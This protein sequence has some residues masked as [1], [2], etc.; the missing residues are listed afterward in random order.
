MPSNNNNTNW[1]KKSGSD[2]IYETTLSLNKYDD[3]NNPIDKTKGIVISRFNVSDGQIQFFEKVGSTE[4]LMTT[5]DAD[6]SQRFDSGNLYSTYFDADDSNNRGQQL[7]QVLDLTKNQAVTTAKEELSPEDFSDIFENSERYKSVSNDSQTDPDTADVSPESNPF[8][9]GSN[10]YNREPIPEGRALLRYPLT[11][12]DLGYD[13]I[14]I[15]AYEYTAGGR[16]SLTLGQ[17]LSAKKR[18]IR[19]ATKKETVILPMQPNFSESNAVSWGGDNLNPIQM[20][21]AGFAEGAIKAIGNLGAPDEAKKIIGETFKQLD[22]DVD[23]ILNDRISGPALIAYFAGQ[24]VGANILGRSAG[25]TLN[26]NLELLFKG[27]NLRTFNFNF[28]FTP[29]SPKEA[30]EVKEIIRVFKKNMAVQ[31]STSNLFL[32]TPRVFTVEYIYNAQGSSAGEI[33]P[34]L[35]IFKPMAM[36]NLNVNYTPDGT[37]MT[38]NQDGSLTSYDLQMSF[39]ELEPIY[40]DEFDDPDDDAV[41][42]FSQHKNMGY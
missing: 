18:I 31:R 12:P 13:F 42:S 3:P 11:V 37:Y 4:T 25:V 39:G 30:R 36:T 22:K 24:A 38:Y 19:D 26:P 34:Y 27:P 14:R 15:T 28:R 20:M 23:E 33:H 32:L 40:A 10:A 1:E 8:D 17:K 6:G 7:N 29:R 16:Q 21:G 41:G 5:F 2:T 9:Q 35:N